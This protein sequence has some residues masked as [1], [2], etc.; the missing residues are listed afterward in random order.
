M[1]TVMVRTRPMCAFVAFL[2]SA[3]QLWAANDIP[4]ATVDNEFHFIVL[5]DAQFDNPATFNRTIDQVKRLHPA[6]VIQVGDLIEGYHS[7][8]DLIA[9][10]WRRFQRQI[11]PLSDI[12]FFAIAGNHDV[13]GGNKVP[14]ERLEALFEEQWGPLYFT[15][16]YKNALI[17]GLNSDS[18]EAPEQISDEQI[19]WMQNVLSASDAEHRFVFMHRPPMLMSNGPRLHEAFRQGGVDEVIYGHHHH[20]HHFERDGVRYTMTNA[21]G[22]MAH[23]VKLVGGFEHLLQVSIRDSDRSVAAIEI[24]AIHAQDMV[25]PKDNY[26]LFTL[27]RSLVKRVAT[28]SPT[29]EKHNFQF[30]LSLHNKSERAITTFI[31]CTSQDGRWNLLP[32]QIPTTALQPGAQAQVVVAASFSQGR[33]PESLPTCTVKVPFQTFRGEWLDLTETVTTRYASD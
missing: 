2:L 27:G 21:S 9:E 5:G 13:Y 28:L 18:R 19:R 15:F 22:R 12:P 33:F 17:I 8:L 25:T 11:A 29:R 10:E 16:T 3:A 31:S 7:N 1:R 14:D 26:D 4:P 23:E 32:N 24:D 6:F 30:T 20:Y